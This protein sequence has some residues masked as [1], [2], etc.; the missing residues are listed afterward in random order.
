MEIAKHFQLL[1]I[2]TLETGISKDG[3]Y[4]L[5]LKKDTEEELPFVVEKQVLDF[6]EEVWYSFAV[7]LTPE[8]NKAI[9]KKASFYQ[10]LALLR[11]TS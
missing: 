9:G 6:V 3:C 11:Q 2:A 8:Y 10:P 5:Q 7:N 1:R 4:K